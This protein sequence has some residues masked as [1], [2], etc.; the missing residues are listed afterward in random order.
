MQIPK[1]KPGKYTQLKVD[2][3]ITQ[4]K[5]QTFEAELERLKKIH[6]AAAAEVKRLAELGDFSENAAYQQAKSRLRGINERIFFLEDRIKHAVIIEPT[7][8]QTVG[9]GSTVTLLINDQEKVYTILG[10]AETDPS[11]GVISHSSPLGV[12]LMG[13][14][15]GDAVLLPPTDREVTAHIIAIE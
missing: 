14:K 12:A 11:R 9:L 10:S 3:H 13:H 1:R 7:A 2:P 6:P 4:E 5:K 15:V 8:A